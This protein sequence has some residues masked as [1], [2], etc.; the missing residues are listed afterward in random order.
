MKILKEKAESEIV[1][2]LVGDDPSNRHIA[3][4]V[5]LILEKMW[6]EERL[7]EFIDA[8]HN[9]LCKECSRAR[10]SKKVIAAF[11]AL[12]TGLITALGALFKSWF[13]SGGAAQ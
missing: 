5:L 10:L 7:A 2:R 4:G 12:G 11:G 3:E 8:R 1:A 13:G 6:S 9:A